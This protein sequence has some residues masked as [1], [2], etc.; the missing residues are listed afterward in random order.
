MEFK[1]KIQPY[2]TDVVDNIV[3]VFEGE[4]FDNR[5]MYAVDQGPKYN[6]QVNPKIIEGYSNH[7]IGL[8]D[9]QILSNIRRVQAEAN[10]GNSHESDERIGRCSLDI[11]M[12]TGTGKTYVYIKTMFELNK[13]YGWNKFIVVVPSIAIREGVNKTFEITEEHFWQCYEKRVHYFIYDSSNLQELETYS[14]NKGISVMI[15]NM[16]A[17]ATSLKEDGKS[18]DSRIIYSERDDFQSRRPID[19]IAANNPIIILDEP[20]KL[21]GEV[22]QQA[23]KKNFNALFSL[24]FSATHN[25]H[26]RL[27]YSLDALDAY[28]QKLVKRIEVKGI[29]TR[30]LMG[31]TCYMY[32]DSIIKNPDA[33]PRARI[34]MEISRSTGIKREIRTL[35]GGDNLYDESNNLTEY[36]GIFIT[37]IDVDR[38]YVEFNT[39]L[40]LF[41]GEVI[42]DSS[43]ETL[44]RIQIRETIASHFEKEAKLFDK[45]I[46][47]LSLF[48]ID[49][50]DKYRQYD[51]LGNS[52]LGSYGQ[53]FEEEYNGLLHELMPSF[54]PDYQ[55][56]LKSFDVGSVHKGYF[57]IDKRSKRIIDSSRK[58]K[59]EFSD[60]VDAYDLIMKDKERLLSFE[61]PTRFIFSH[62]ALSEGWDNPNV[63]Q[64]CAL[65]HSDNDNRKRQEVGRGLRLC[66]NSEG[67][68][69]DLEECGQLIHEINTLTVVASEGY[70]SFVK[71]LQDE[72]SKALRERPIKVDAK[73]IGRLK[74][75][76]GTDGSIPADVANR[77]YHQLYHEGLID[78]S[79]E[80][81][82]KC[83]E[84]VR[85]GSGEGI[86]G[87][88]SEF[89][90]YNGQVFNLLSAAV[91]GKFPEGLIGKGK[92]VRIKN[93]LNDNYQKKEFQSLWN[94]IN[95]KY[96]YRVEFDSQELIDKSV[97]ALEGLTVTVLSSLI[98]TGS[99]KESITK[100][101]IKDGTSFGYDGQETRA[102][103]GCAS[104]VKYDLVGLIASGSNITR[105]T[106]VAILKSMNR[107]KFELFIENPE[108]FIRKVCNIIKSQKATMII[109]HVM[110]NTLNETY[111]NKIF[112]E[113]QSTCSFRNA[114]RA[115]RHIKDYVF[116]DGLAEDSV[117]KRFAEELDKSK[118]V[119]V[120]AKLPGGFKIPTPVG[121]YTPDW[122]IAFDENSGI[123]HIYFIAE[124][125]GTSNSLQ[126]RPIEQAKIHCAERI[127]NIPDSKVRYECV[128]DYATLLDMLRGK[129]S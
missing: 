71:G 129:E 113:N 10:L 104:S 66:V 83:R 81:T 32:L 120:Y 55:N 43:E 70:D 77:I 29:E 35:D 123:K 128:T 105:K 57:S 38:E 100:D 60:D 37:D 50:V 18:K 68:R 64:I 3:R 78:D 49:R 45:G 6:R 93:K 102:I 110:Y 23:L 62:S 86:F 89:A 73:V 21:S 82:K 54:N 28:N 125:K 74:I 16:Q 46:K 19:V 109:D 108:E 112:T 26:H 33:P 117:E 127:Y 61:E 11:E 79:D 101:E 65:K 96:S 118:E 87:P 69:M 114:Y 40:R 107:D 39:G 67:K 111:D 95:H 22:T 122:A 103:G 119:V 94:E 116:T 90:Q 80:P 124:T 59:S 47:C 7:P 106:A 91:D 58:G 75:G 72:M 31:N 2:Q 56:Y 92:E 27:V 98:R 99:Q 44:R 85:S 42:G 13:H 4:G 24:N 97:M 63:F 17:F 48:F 1:F 5:Y 30:N 121:D 9:D 52:V 51:E 34:E 14:R 84:I 126:L 88:T 36:E 41:L 115:K 20:Q 53:M 8:S 25:K 76:D 15:I 12:E